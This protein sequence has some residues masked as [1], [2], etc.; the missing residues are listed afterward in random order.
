MKR[1]NNVKCLVLLLSGVM[2]IVHQARAE[3]EIGFKL[4]GK[5]HCAI[6][7]KTN[8]FGKYS[9]SMSH[10]GKTYVASYI[11]NAD[12]T[13]D[14]TYANGSHSRH[15]WGIEV[16]DDSPVMYPL[17]NKGGKEKMM[18]YNM[19]VEC[20]EGCNLK[21]NGKYSFVDVDPKWPKMAWG[22]TVYEKN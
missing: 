6:E 2:C 15:R 12:G 21:I 10:N 11:I 9:H 7:P 17:A 13:L 16:K 20:I 3:C 1:I 19:V 22:T 14:F 4:S 18:V 5:P 8:F